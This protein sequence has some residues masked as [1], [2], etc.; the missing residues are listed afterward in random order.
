MSKHCLSKFHLALFIFLL[1]SLAGNVLADIHSQNK[2]PERALD[3]AI[4]KIRLKQNVAAAAYIIV[5][6]NRVLHS[7]A[8][9]ISNRE[10]QQAVNLDT[11]FR[12]GS[13]TK[14]FTSLALLK[15]QEQGKLS[16]EDKLKHLVSDAPLNNPWHKT[17]PVS[18]AQLLEHTAGLSD[19][20]KEEFDYVGPKTF[21]KTGAEQQKTL[22]LRQGL[23]FNAQA[24][25]SLWPPGL[26]KSY[27]NAGAGY[28]AFILEKIT[29]ET[30]ESYV[31]KHLFK[32][33]LMKHASFTLNEDTK[34]HLATGYDTDGDT[35]IPYW[36]M[37]MRPFGAINTTPNEMSHFVQMLLND[38]KFQEKTIFQKNS[39]KRMETPHT[40][41]AASIDLFFGYGLGSDQH[42]HNGFVFYGHSGDA[43]G[44]LARFAYNRDT[45]KGY[46]LVINAYNYRAINSIETQIEDYIT[47][48]HKK[49]TLPLEAKIKLSDL[50]RYT[51]KYQ[52]V[53]HRFPWKTSAQKLQNK[54]EITLK[55][56]TLQIKMPEHIPRKLIAVKSSHFRY[57][58]EPV[59][60]MAFIEYMGKMYFQ[61]EAGSYVK[62]EK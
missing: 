3:E 18:I 46:F 51:G 57:R 44:Y 61:G 4:N 23:Y 12:I 2:T 5:S 36:H 47:S 59:A 25:K 14:S 39:I 43:D 55:N 49:P 62:L 6:K 16:L 34:Q 58:N 54:L 28:A 32:P 8:F 33:L 20:T 40:T 50:K 15:L 35:V 17:H 1:L 10:T 9:G 21:N 22:S 37:I 29:G 30:Y 27:S 7:A 38:G 41:L 52:A 48:G 11:V 24:R 31:Q 56:N 26:H 13:I 42:I 45:G 60:T 19:L 53:T